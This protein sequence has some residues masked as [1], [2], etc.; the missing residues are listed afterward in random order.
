MVAVVVGGVL[1]GAATS[2]GLLCNEGMFT[3]H[4]TQPDPS[5][6]LRERVMFSFR[7][8]RKHTQN[9]KKQRHSFLV[10]GET[11]A[12]THALKQMS[13][14][15]VPPPHNQDITTQHVQYLQLSVSFSSIGWTIPE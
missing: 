11:R 14:H 7:K 12:C 8:G 15:F 10:L 13:V 2:R 5:S 3:L 6:F 1:A 9:C 4:P